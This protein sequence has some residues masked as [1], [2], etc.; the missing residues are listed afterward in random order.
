MYR[1]AATT[2]LGLGGDQLYAGAEQGFAEHKPAFHEEM[3]NLAVD[4]GCHGRSCN[5]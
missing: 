2:Q 1:S 4:H 3:V 5:R